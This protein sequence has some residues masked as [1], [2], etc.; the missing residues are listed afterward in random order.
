MEHTDEEIKQFVKDGKVLEE[1]INSVITETVKL[2]Y[3]QGFETTALPVTSISA[4]IT[5]PIVLLEAIGKTFPERNVKESSTL[6][7]LVLSELLATGFGGKLKDLRK[8]GVI[9]NAKP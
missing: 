5:V 9:T 7:E 6:L 3:I 1:I 8:R 4:P 2:T